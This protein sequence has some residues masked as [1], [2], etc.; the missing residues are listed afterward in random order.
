MKKTKKGETLLEVIITI[1]IL[2]IIAASFLAVFSNGLAIIYRFG[3][4]TKAVGEAKIILNNVCENKDISSIPSEWKRIDDEKK[5]YIYDSS[6][7]K[8][9]FIESCSINKEYTYQKITIVI[10]YDNGKMHTQMTA[11]IPGLKGV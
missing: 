1:S 6:A 10:F 3:E 4:K 11:V 7:P 2:G 5:L 8:K 9:Y